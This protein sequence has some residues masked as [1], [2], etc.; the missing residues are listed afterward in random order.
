MYFCNKEERN[1]HTTMDLLIEKINEL[2]DICTENGISHTLDLPQIVVIGSQSSGKTSVLE[3]IVGKDFLPRGSGIVTRRPLILQ[4]IYT[5]EADEEYGV[6]NHCPTK[7]F[8]SF[9][10]VRQ[11][12]TDETNRHIKAKNDVSHVPIT[13]KLYSSK[14]LTLT[15]VDLPGLVKVPTGDQPKNICLK[16]EEM[17]KRF[18]SNK[19]AIILAVTA[20]NVDIS[21]SDALHLARTVDSCYER[22]IGVLTKVDLMDPGTDIVDVLAGRILTLKLGFV[23]VVNRGQNDIERKKSIR[24]ALE[25]EKIF[26]ES[27]S[28]YRRNK[29]Y[30][31][32]LYLV[33]KLNNVLHEHIKACLPG[34]QE[35]INVLLYENQLEL[36]RMGCVNLSPK[37]SILRIIND[38]NKK[39]TDVL[40]GNCDI[41]STEIY[42]G[43]RLNYTFHSHFSKFISSLNAMESLKDES[44]RTLLYNSTG[45]S[46]LLLFSH[47]AFEKLTKTSISVLKPH[48][49]KLISVI[50]NELVKII[51]AVCQSV[52]GRFP[53]LNDKIISC[54]I[55]LLKKNSEHTHNLV[56][57][58]IDWNM[59]YISTRHPDFIKWNEVLTKEIE[60]TEMFSFKDDNQV[61]KS[62]DKRITFDSPPNILKINSAISEQEMMEIN[63]I[64]SLVVSYF[65]IIKKIVV[66]QIPK[67]I[68]CEL[69]YKSEEKMQEILFSE[70]YECKGIEDLVTESDETSEKRKRLE[71]NIKALKQ[72]YDLMCSI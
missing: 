17:C 5:K 40:K 39:F 14:V 55:G 41:S 10:A 4:L 32:T 13:L 36:S 68:M 6:F 27:H 43:A 25:D 1:M 65:E 64:K 3:N 2:Q 50:F 58:F 62:K 70:I 49:L 67:A 42:G 61:F 44:I 8:R 51:H 47:T 71:K 35:K 63:I 56:S 46:S 72:A 23:P 31:G 33:T 45:S 48:S 18:I 7:I 66:D 30:C 22:T 12:I 59:N 16:I 20:A 34:L 52:V 15:L 19:N 38:L 24:L 29:Q 21:N 37:E 57:S 54:L 9:E 53:S 28:S 69:V 11:E 26:F 60:R